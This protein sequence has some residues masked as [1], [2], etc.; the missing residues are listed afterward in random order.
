MRILFY[1]VLM[2]MLGAGS[3]YLIGLLFGSPLST[4]TVNFLGCFLLAMVFDYFETRWPKDL[5]GAVGTGFIGA[6][7]TF[8]AFSTETVNLFIG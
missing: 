6:F 3:R 4:L 8:S 5:V 1:T 7:T 2:G